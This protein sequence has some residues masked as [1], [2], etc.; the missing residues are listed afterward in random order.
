LNEQFRS[1]LLAF[2]E[3]SKHC[4]AVKSCPIVKVVAAAARAGLGAECASI[5][6]VAIALAA[7]LD[8]GDI[9]FDSPAKTNQQLR[10]C[11]AKGVHINA[12]NLD[13]IAEIASIVGG[14]GGRGFTS[15]SVV[16]LRINPQT[17]SSSMLDLFTSA[18]SSKFGAPLKET[19]S[20]VIQAFDR[21]P[22][23]TCIHV[24]GDYRV[25]TLTFSRRV[26]QQP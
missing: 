23:L 8:P 11:L 13:E 19:R 4:F 14:E 5:G 17:G 2:P 10:F 24:H 20:Q 18:S 12:D 26:Q 21:Y 9:V 7:G 3:S 1:L 16:G 15:S 6:E 22:F 25:A